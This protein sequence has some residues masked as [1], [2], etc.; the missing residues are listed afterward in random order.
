MLGVDTR[1]PLFPQRIDFVLGGGAAAC[2]R[3]LPGSLES[4]GCCLLD[5]E[6]GTGATRVIRERVMPNGAGL[7]CITL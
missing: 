7:A 2:Q 1:D 4:V 6:V 5:V 3:G